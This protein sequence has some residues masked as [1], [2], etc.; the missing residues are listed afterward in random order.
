MDNAPKESTVHD[1]NEA[2]SCFMWRLISKIVVS[3]EGDTVAPTG[4][5][6]GHL[7][8]TQ[9]TPESESGEMRVIVG[10]LSLAQTKEVLDILDHRR[11]KDALAVQDQ[12]M[13]ED[14]LIVR[15]N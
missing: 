1:L 6:L 11:N 13:T 9:G 2:D 12:E 4:P 8:F 5:G 3:R 10:R 15:S 14:Y 7:V